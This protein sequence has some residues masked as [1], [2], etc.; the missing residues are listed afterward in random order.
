MT[1]KI[2]LGTYTKRESKGIYSI[3]LDSDNKKLGNLK[4]EAT[5]IGSPT[6]LASS[7]DGQLLFAVAKTDDNQGGLAVYKKEKD[8]YTHVDTYLAEGAPPCYVAYDETRARVYSANYHKGEVSVFSVNDQGEL[9]LLDTATHSGKSVHENQ[10][11]PHAHYFDLTPDHQFLIACDLG[12]DEVITYKLTD[13]D[14]LDE[15]DV[16][17]VEPGTGPRH[18]VFHPSE[19]YAY[20][21]GE[22]SSEV[23][24]FT[25]NKN[26]GTLSHLQTLPSIP[27]KH[28][29]FNGG[30]AIRLSADGKFLYAS[31]RGHDSLVIYSVKEDGT[32]ELVDYVSTEGEV[33]RDFNLDPS[34]S[35]VVVGH[36]D[37]D[38]LTLFERN[39][40]DGTLKLLQKD[41]YAPEVVA[42]T[43][44]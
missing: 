31:N 40:E 1:Q 20:V 43:F 5:D 7:K 8:A 21:F 10:Q 35:F 4:V 14:K 30:A 36:Q 15:V 37:S 26:T 3:E 38:N 17:S 18:I 16:I 11:S 13:E 42:V 9:A 41:V 6:Y 32:L 19:K 33:P 27:N 25:Y 28:T 39:K 29:S 2:L 22:L 24:A 34:D 12:T 44:I 23:L